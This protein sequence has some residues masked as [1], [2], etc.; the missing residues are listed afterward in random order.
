MS[1]IHDIN[2]AR[3]EIHD[4]KHHVDSLVKV[5]QWYVSAMERGSLTPVQAYIRYQE[6]L[7]TYKEWRSEESF[8]LEDLV[9]MNIKPGASTG[10]LSDLG[11]LWDLAL[12]AKALLERQGVKF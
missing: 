3:N 7:R 2:A 8:L 9:R 1:S 4:L 5:I 10:N 6:I 11:D 12:R